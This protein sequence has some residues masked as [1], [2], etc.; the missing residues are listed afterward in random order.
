MLFPMRI[1]LVENHPDTLSY[2]RRHLLRAGHEVE[3][4]ETFSDALREI[5]GKP[6]DVLIADLGLPDG[7]GWSLLAQLGDA[8]PPFAIAISGR[9][10]PEDRARSAEAGFQ[11]HLVKPF[12]PDELDL[13][14]QK[15]S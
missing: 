6:R 4:A 2:M 9:S 7:D 10:S 14:L 5:P 12:S 1:F 11:E 8:R 3:T 13:A 15:A